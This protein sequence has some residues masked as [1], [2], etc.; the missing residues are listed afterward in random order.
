MLGSWLGLQAGWVAIFGSAA[1][2]R[3]G[4]ADI[5]S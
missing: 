1:W 5:T 4:D 2:A 3:L